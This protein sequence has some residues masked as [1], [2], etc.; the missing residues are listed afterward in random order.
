[1]K[2]TNGFISNS[3]SSSFIVKD[4]NKINEAKQIL[5]KFD[6]KYIELRNILYTEL[7]SS[8]T[9][10]TIPFFNAI[11]DLDYFVDYMDGSGYIPYDEENATEIEEDIWIFNDDLLDEDY[12]KYHLI[13]R[14][15][16]DKIYLQVQKYLNKEI[17][18]V[19]LRKQCKLILKGED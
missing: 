12:L 3:S 6:V 13:P 2:V 16:A 18:A 15:F 1:M 5:E 10:E 7:V 17:K 8:D 19:E 14:H 11:R 9:D 4:I